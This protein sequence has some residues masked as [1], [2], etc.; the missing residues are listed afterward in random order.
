MMTEIMKFGILK[1]YVI[2]KPKLF[3]I[4][5]LLCPKSEEEE[6]KKLMPQA[7]P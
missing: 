5:L 2:R 6:K 4:R 1:S 3:L 7:L